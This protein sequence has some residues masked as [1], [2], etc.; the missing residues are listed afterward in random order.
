MKITSV[1]KYVRI[2][3]SKVFSFARLLKGVPVAK[4]LA[5]TKFS[6]TKAAALIDKT[7]KSAIANAENNQKL[8]AED[9]R[10]ENVIIER[11]P[12][13]KRYWSRSRGMPRPIYKQTS[14][15]RVSLVND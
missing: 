8:S 4:A 14:H 6:N 7:L 1:S 2:S 12:R 10:V 3:P 11:G 15:I 9:F 5:M 13:S